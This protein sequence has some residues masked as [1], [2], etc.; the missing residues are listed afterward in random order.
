MLALRHVDH[1][2]TAATLPA[3]ALLELL[4][5]LD[6]FRRPERFEDFLLVCRADARLP[7]DG[8]DYPPADRMHAARDAAAAVGVNDLVA[9]GENGTVI[10]AHLRQRRILA[11]QEISG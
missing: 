11:I 6:A 4:S 1:A 7:N 2:H 5:D 8:V 9:A 10:A 3:V